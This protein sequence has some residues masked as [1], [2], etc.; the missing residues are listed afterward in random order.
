M[1]WK[2]L[3]HI[4]GLSYFDDNTDNDIENSANKYRKL[5]LMI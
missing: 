4:D 5:Y 1:K 3:Y 2:D